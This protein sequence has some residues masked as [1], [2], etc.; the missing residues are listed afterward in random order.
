MFKKINNKISKT[1]DFLVKNPKKIVLFFSVFLY[2]ITLCKIIFMRPHT[3]MV[4]DGALGH[5]IDYVTFFLGN[6]KS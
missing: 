5:K 4:E 2:G 6:L 3:L 1:F